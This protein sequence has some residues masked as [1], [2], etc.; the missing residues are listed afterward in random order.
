MTLADSIKN[1][2]SLVFISTND[3]AESVTYKPHN[4]PG[5]PVRSDRTIN[6]IVIR[7]AVAVLG[8]DGDVVVDSFEVHV[9][10]N[11]TKGIASDE[12]DTGG[13]RLSFASKDG[14]AAS[15]HS[16]LRVITRDTGMLVLE[17]R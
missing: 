13:D 5:K 7:Q 14:I 15:D 2:G 4:F 12:V 6:A 10:N 9:A 16:V 1:D 17:C 11:A 8:E 3:F